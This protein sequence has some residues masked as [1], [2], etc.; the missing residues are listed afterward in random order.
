MQMRMSNGG[1]K[2]TFYLCY[3]EERIMNINVLSV[4]WRE[5]VQEIAFVLL[6]FM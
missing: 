4:P 3:D 5:K 2:G 6:S 1:F